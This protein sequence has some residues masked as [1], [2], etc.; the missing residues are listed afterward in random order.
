MN[1]Q[2]KITHEIGGLFGLG[3]TNFSADIN[4]EKNQFYNNEMIKLSVTCD[5]SKCRKD[6]D[7]FKMKL[8]RH[9]FVKADGKKTDVW[10]FGT[11]KGHAFST[12]P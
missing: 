7:T 2:K 6:I 5:N 9:Y 11:E 3:S 1:L 10:P 4:F 8:Y 12:T